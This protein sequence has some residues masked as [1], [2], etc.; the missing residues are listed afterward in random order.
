MSTAALEEN[1][2][3][4]NNKV[5]LR[6]ASSQGALNAQ[7]SHVKPDVSD[8]SPRMEPCFFLFTLIQV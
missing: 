8:S 2:D 1:N 4:S 5:E 6:E 3:G 7:T